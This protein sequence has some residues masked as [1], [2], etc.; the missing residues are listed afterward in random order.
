MVDK[1]TILF[2]YCIKSANLFK[3]KVFFY[4]IH[5]SRLDLI[6]PLIARLNQVRKDTVR[7][8]V[9]LKD[10]FVAFW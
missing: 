9:M 10:R 8:N 3:V 4:C 7:Q 2:T 6:F 5:Y 1:D